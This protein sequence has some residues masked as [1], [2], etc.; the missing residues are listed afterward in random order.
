M[1]ITIDVVISVGINSRTEYAKDATFRRKTDSFMTQIGSIRQRQRY[2]SR[3]PRA[4]A[5]HRAS[6]L[7]EERYEEKVIEARSSRSIMIVCMEQGRHKRE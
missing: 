1:A 5:L 4:E 2:P 7:L 6:L 3:S